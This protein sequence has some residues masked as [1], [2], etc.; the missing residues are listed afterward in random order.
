LILGITTF[1]FNAKFDEL[2][3]RFQN[4]GVINS[5]NTTFGT[6]FVQKM[7]FD[8][9]TKRVVFK[10]QGQYKGVASIWINPEL[11][12][13]MFLCQSMASQD[14]RTLK[15]AIL[16]ENDRVVK[17]LATFTSSG[18]LTPLRVTMSPNQT[19]HIAVVTSKKSSFDSVLVRADLPGSL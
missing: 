1:S 8:A 11:K 16:D 12:E 6:S 14:G 18:E 17:D 2:G 3:E 5:L 10:P 7:L 9:D 13:A 4:E 19:G 15:L